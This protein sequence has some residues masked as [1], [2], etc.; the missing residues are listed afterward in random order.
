MKIEDLIAQAK[1][2]CSSEES[3]EVL[4]EKITQYSR[5]FSEWMTASQ[6][7]VLKNPDEAEKAFLL[8]LSKMHEAVLER[9]QQL[10]DFTKKEIGELK[11]RGA[12]IMAYTDSSPSRISFTRP[13]KG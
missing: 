5:S 9:S 10:K 1:D 8:E 3:P 4:L 6:E 13:K 7:S 2:I 11:K 12:G